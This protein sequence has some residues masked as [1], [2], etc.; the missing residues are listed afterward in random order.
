M[1]D[2]LELGER[3]MREVELGAMLHDVGKVS[4]P[5]EV[6]R[7][8]GSLTEEEWALMRGH[9]IEG[10]KMLG[11]FGGLLGEVGSVVRSHHERFD[12]AG[13]PDGLRGEDIPIAARIISVCDAFHAMTSDRPYRDAMSVPAALD[14]L[15]RESGAQFDPTVVAATGPHRGSARGPALPPH[16]RRVCHLERPARAPQRLGP[17]RA[18]GDSAPWTRRAHRRSIEGIQLT[19]TLR[20]PTCASR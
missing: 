3:E 6:I 14:E 5:G 11:Q 10:E 15:R 4:I 2:H 12:G 1:G 18:F 9:T 7:K 17:A 13:Y 8:P 20:R 19:A 16:R